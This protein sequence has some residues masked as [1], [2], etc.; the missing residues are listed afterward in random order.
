MPYRYVKPTNNPTTPPLAA[1]ITVGLVAIIASVF[2]VAGVGDV[3]L[4]LA[5]GTWWALMTPLH[6]VVSIGFGVI[7]LFLGS[8]FVVVVAEIVILVGTSV[9]ESLQRIVIKFRKRIGQ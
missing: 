3:T 8:L 9:L 5:K 2:T 7:T 6:F 4:R 1:T